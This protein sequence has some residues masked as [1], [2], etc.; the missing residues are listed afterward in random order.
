MSATKVL[1][2]HHKDMQSRAQVVQVGC[3]GVKSQGMKSGSQKREVGHARDPLLSSL[4]FPHL[5]VHLQKAGHASPL[6]VYI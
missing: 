6:S 5:I 1:V 2:R 3:K 4:W